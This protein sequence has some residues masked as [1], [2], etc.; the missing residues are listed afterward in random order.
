MTL[1]EALPWLGASG[2]LLS[3]GFFSGAET[4][5]FSLGEEQVAI[6]KPRVRRLLSQPRELLVTILTSKI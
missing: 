4:A 5:L 1:G 6:A 3:S 2:M